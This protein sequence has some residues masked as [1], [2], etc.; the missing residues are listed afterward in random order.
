MSSFAK[1]FL[2]ICIG[3]AVVGYLAYSVLLPTYHIRYRLSLDVEVDGKVETSSSVIEISYQ[4]LPD[5]LEFAG[6]PGGAFHGFMHGARA[7]D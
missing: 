4:I 1:K 2:T 6:G 7:D 3:A 5:S